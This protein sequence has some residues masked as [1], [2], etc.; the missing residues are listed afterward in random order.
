MKESYKTS[1][2][3]PLRDRMTEM[4][5]RGWSVEIVNFT[6]GIRGSFAETRWT[7][8]LMAL[9]VSAAGVVQLME[10]LVGQCR[11]ELNVL[12]STRA[13]ALRQKADAHG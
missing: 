12:Y 6:L 3:Q 11:T 4:L 5:P 2:Y 10:A 1:R 8:A 9:G 7:A 13:A